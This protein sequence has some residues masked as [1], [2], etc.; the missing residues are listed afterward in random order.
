MAKWIIKAGKTYLEPY[1]MICMETDNRGI[2]GAIVKSLIDLMSY[3]DD[4]GLTVTVEKIAAPAGEGQE[5]KRNSK[6]ERYQI[7]SVDILAQEG[8]N[9]D[10]I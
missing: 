6:E 3:S 5:P 1:Q 2:A 7:S 10:T 4:P 8:K 9:V